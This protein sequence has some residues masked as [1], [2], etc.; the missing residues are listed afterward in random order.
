MGRHHADDELEL[1]HRRGA[2]DPGGA[3]DRPAEHGHPLGLQDGRPG[4]DPDR[5]PAGDTARDAASDSFSRPAL[6]GP[7]PERR[8]EHQSRVEGYIPAAGRRRGRH[9]PRGLEPRHLDGPLPYLRAPRSRHDD[10]V[11][12]TLRPAGRF[13]SQR[14]S[15]GA[16]MHS[17]LP[18][19]RS[20]RRPADRLRWPGLMVLIGAAV[21]PAPAR[22]PR[23]DSLGPAVRPGTPARD[24]QTVVIE[25]GWITAVGPAA[26]V[27]PPA[28]AVVMDLGGHTVIPGLVG[29]HDHLYYTAAGGRS[30]QLTYTAPRCNRGGR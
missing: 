16:P 11:H 6:P 1:D 22:A 27:K 15:I 26:S 13:S 10:D 28:G 18:L 20:S 14:H 7:G 29:M 21:F 19:T 4:Q 12:G 8:P 24:D 23:P 2:L 17:S 30:A 9:S 3:G 5:E 25:K